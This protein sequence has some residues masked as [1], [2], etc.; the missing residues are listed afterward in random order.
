[1]SVPSR[2]S[3]PPRWWSHPGSRGRSTA[4]ESQRVAGATRRPGLW[5]TLTVPTRDTERCPGCH[6][7]VSVGRP[8]GVTVEIVRDL[9]ADGREEITISIGRVVVHHCML[10][11]DGE[12]R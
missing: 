5:E 4:T 11:P 7:E 6:R 8:E 12:W 2:F 3:P 10:F 1:M 9:T